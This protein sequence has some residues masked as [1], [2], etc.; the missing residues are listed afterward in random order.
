[1]CSIESYLT[2]SF[3]DDRKWSADNF[4]IFIFLDQNFLFLKTNPLLFCSNFEN[5][6]NKQTNKQ[7]SH[8]LMLLFMMMTIFIF[9]FSSTKKSENGQIK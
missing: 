9:Q 4:T 3:H 5:L 2:F 7:K 1:M 8:Y 6:W